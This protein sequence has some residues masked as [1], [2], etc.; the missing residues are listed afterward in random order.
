M[1][2]SIHV[3][4]FAGEI[5]IIVAIVAGAVVA[6]ALFQ[7]R[8][9]AEQL[10]RHNDVA[11]YLFSAVGVIYAVVLGFVVVVVWEKYDATAANV[12]TE[13]AAVA[14]LYRSVGG[15][16]NPVRDRVRA[17]LCEYARR[18]AYREWPH[19][20]DPRDDRRDLA[21]LERA[22]YRIDAYQPRTVAESNAQ[23][24]AMTQRTRLFD[25][26][27]LR[28]YQAVPSIPAVLWV[29]LYAGALAMLAFAFLFGVENRPMQL[30]MT[31]I[32]AGVIALLFVVIGEFDQPF[33]GSVRLSPDAWIALLRHLPNIP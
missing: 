32:L 19:M 9:R 26:R 3:P 15:F 11:G 23:Q 27:R 14:D 10:R 18:V 25:A 17:E 22:A 6:H 1:R 16:S 5:A 20:S 2:T 13:V 7:R 31:A 4:Q 33:S 21:L 28:Y 24:M 29:A 8:F 30:L 12:T